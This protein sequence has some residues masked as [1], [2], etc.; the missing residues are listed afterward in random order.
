MRCGIFKNASCSI[1]KSSDWLHP[2]PPLSHSPLN[3]PPPSQHFK[4]L[5]CW[6]TAASSYR[7]RSRTDLQH[8]LTRIRLGSHRPLDLRF[9]SLLRFSNSQTTS[10]SIMQ[11]YSSKIGA[12][13]DRDRL[14]MAWGFPLFP[15]WEL[16]SSVG[17]RRSR[18]T[19]N[20]FQLDIIT[21]RVLPG[22]IEQWSSLEFA[23]ILWYVPFKRQSGLWLLIM[24]RFFVL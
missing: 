7:S 20:R 14:L 19:K 23:T 2:L 8:L 4:P 13:S 16:I 24:A 3:H 11:H 22:S 1:V 10:C 6:R 17:L 15:L 5:S 12:H 21:L 9:R 18:S